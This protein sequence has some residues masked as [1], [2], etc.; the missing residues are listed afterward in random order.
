[1]GHE[2]LD[3]FDTGCVERLLTT[4]RSV[5][6]R[7]DLEAPVDLADVHDALRIATQAPT[8]SNN[9]SWRFLVVTDPATRA[10]LAA[11]YRK[12]LTVYAAALAEMSD[13]GMDVPVLPDG[14]RLRTLDAQTVRSMR[15]A[16][17]LT[18]H[19]HEVPVHVVPCLLGRLP[20]GADTFRQ[21]AYWGSIHPAVW[22]L[23][24]ALRAK[25]YGSVYTTLHLAN[26]AEAAELLGLPAHVTQC[27]LVPVARVAGGFHP[28]WREPV[29]EVAYLE[30]WGQ[31]FV[32]P[33]RG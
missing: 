1:M 7:L 28:A 32:A 22:S 24:L 33:E 14:D 15:S 8:G 23:Q 21:A 4:T 12:G 2:A 29:D 17:Y 25:G 9:R 3:G 13:R 20:E 30:R 27:G 18:R 31:G 16:A 6:R 5:R 10:G 11:V 26:E 19:L